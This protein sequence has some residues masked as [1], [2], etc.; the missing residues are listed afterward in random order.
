MPF[1]NHSNNKIAGP[2]T[3]LISDAS[4]PLEVAIAYTWPDKFAGTTYYK[5]GSVLDRNKKWERDDK[6]GI[7]VKHPRGQRSHGSENLKD[8]E[9]AS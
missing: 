6:W 9:L 2:A 8:K 7:K 4:D 1:E 3:V 5:D